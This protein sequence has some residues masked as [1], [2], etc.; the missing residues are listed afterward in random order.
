MALT[1]RSDLYASFKE[2]DINRLLKWV[3]QLRPSLFNYATTDVEAR[4]V[5]DRKLLCAPIKPHPMVR[6]MAQPL[7]T[8]QAPLQLPGTQLGV[9]YLVQLSD[10]KIDFHPKTTVALPPELDPLKPQNLA[11]ELK[12]CGAIGCPDEKTIAQFIPPPPDPERKPASP[13]VSKTDSRRSATT[14]DGGKNDEVIPLGF[15]SLHCFCLKALVTGGMRVT[16]YHDRPYLEPYLD[17]FEIVDIQPA[18]L[19]NSLECL[20]K[21]LL[22][23]VVL[24]KLRMLLSDLTFDITEK[25]RDYFPTHVKLTV[26]PTP[27]SS[28]LP[29]N[30]AIEDDQLKVYVN[31]EVA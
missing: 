10:L 15:E 17:G 27:T 3:M 20:V 7:F 16:R 9:S 30:P 22:K 6:E 2:D 23:L 12:L 11:I 8:R 4:Y 18:E 29:N 5:N 14:K 28:K 26:E 24:P 31:L 1:D 19:E 13:L 21:L 25:A